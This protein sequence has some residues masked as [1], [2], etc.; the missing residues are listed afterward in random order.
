MD[1]LPTL[2]TVYF[3][4]MLPL[5]SRAVERHD[6]LAQETLLALRVLAA[7]EPREDDSEA[8]LRLEAKLDLALELALKQRNPHK[9][10]ARP[11]RIG[12]N[13]LAWEDIEAYQPGDEIELKLFPN[14]ESALAL[15]LPL[16]IRQ[17]NPQPGRTL[18][19]GELKPL[20]DENSRLQWEKWV[21]RCHRRSLQKR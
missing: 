14:P 13:A 4:A 18:Y 12:L 8:T 15:R 5:S 16:T 1:I 17:A 11:C 9:P 6:T 19:L 7:P 10:L 21:F 20:F 3:D 2:D